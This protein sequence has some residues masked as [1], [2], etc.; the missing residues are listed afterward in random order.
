MVRDLGQ[1]FSSC[2]S[3]TVRFRP[4]A[5]CSLLLLRLPT[6]SAFA[7][8]PF[9]R[10]S[11]SQKTLKIVNRSEIPIKFAWE[12]FSTTAEEEVQEVEV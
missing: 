5:L 10:S 4:F 3:P 8:T 9:R 1:G 7:C 6:C 11:Y 2:A 12:A